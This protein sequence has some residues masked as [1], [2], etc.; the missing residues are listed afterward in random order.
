MFDRFIAGKFRR[1]TGF[2]GRLVG[3]L[4]AKGNAFEA[5]WTVSLLNIEP[6]HQV[7]EI[8]FGPGIAIEQAAQKAYQGLVAGIDYAQTMV[9]LASQRNA[10]AIQAG[11]V[12]L[13]QGEASFL[14]YAEGTFDE[15]FTIHCIY[16]WANPVQVLTEIHR[17]LKPGGLLAVTI[18]PKDKWSKK[19]PL[20][21][22]D[23]FT[24]YGGE[25]VAE[26]LTVAG[27][28]H[29]RVQGSL[30]SEKFPGVSVLGNS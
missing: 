23:L 18:M 30:Q 4:M 14:P 29:V 10:V 19:R 28:Q 16:F 22:G 1:P 21:P 5:H 3:K 12:S 8:G 20:P 25:E 9:D 27:F 11:R 2:F 7:L 6:H 24:L 26:L 15:V 13:Q 17:V